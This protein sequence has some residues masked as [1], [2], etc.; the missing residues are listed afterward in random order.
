MFMPSIALCLIAKNE[1]ALI[2]A[3]LDS[4][5]KAVDQVIVVD[6]GSTDETVAIARAKGAE[7]V[8]F[9]W[10]DDFSAARNAALPLVRCDWVLVLD[11]DE[12]LASD[13]CQKIRTAV[14]QA[15]A[16]A[17]VL[18]LV[19]ADSMDAHPDEVVS[20]KKALREPIWLP[21]LF[22]FSSD[23]IWEGRVHEN[24]SAWMGH[25]NG[26]VAAVDAHIAH[27]GCVPDYR[28][29]RGNSDRNLKLLLAQL[30]EKPNDWFSRTFLLEE[31][32]VRNDPTIHTHKAYLE[33]QL[34]VEL[35]PAVA[36]G[37][38]QTGIVKT[39]TVCMAIAANRADFPRVCHW[40]AQARSVGIDHP[41][42]D[43][44]EGLALERL[45][46]SD[47]GVDQERLGLARDAYLRVLSIKE[48]VWVDGLIA[49]IRGWNSIL[50]LSTVLLQL[51]HL[52]DA[53]EGFKMVSEQ[54]ALAEEQAAMGQAEVLIALG[55]PE[56][57]LVLIFPWMEAE[58][59]NCDAA[60]LAGAACEALGDPAA[61]RDFWIC[62][63]NNARDGLKGLHRLHLLNQGLAA[64]AS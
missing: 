56:E 61:A 39:L 48:K 57:A 29:S 51:G 42:I 62:A 13:A 28:E 47:H 12:R 55:R 15:R 44:M 45:S 54:N 49:G 43:F 63:A 2:G 21:R 53:L 25:R 3:C 22:R 16:E 26:H 41:N 19:D 33:N 50:R 31:L 59:Q 7:I 9:K 24:L 36:A 20:G 10:C 17:Y 64:M 46:M 34:K 18:P 11:C 52:E 40:V 27:Y 38:A 4:A 58:P 32:L 1:A 37:R 5:A 35:L 23:L 14:A 6:T 30:E 8:H 60:I